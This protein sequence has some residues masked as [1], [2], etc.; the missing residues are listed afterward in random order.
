MNNFPGVQVLQAGVHLLEKIDDGGV[1]D[2]VRVRVH[3]LLHVAA[4]AVLHN[5]DVAPIARQAVLERERIE[6]LDH[7]RVV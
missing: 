2:A 1:V 4:V 5:N 6:A 7:V 3:E